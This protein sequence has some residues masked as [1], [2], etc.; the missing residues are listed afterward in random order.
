MKRR[1]SYLL[2]LAS[3]GLVLTTPALADNSASQTGY[4]AG[5]FVLAKRSDN[6]AKPEL[7]RDSREEF[8]ARD[9]NVQ[10]R[11]SVRHGAPSDYGYG[12]E[13]RHQPRPDER[14]YD[15]RGRR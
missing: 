10:E 13:R 4:S 12:Y 1:S 7:R 2:G 6:E 8:R 14:G 15:E 3:L 9:R 5:G 11:E